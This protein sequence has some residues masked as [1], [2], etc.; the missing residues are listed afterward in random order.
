MPW[1][2]KNPRFAGSTLAA[3]RLHTRSPL[4]EAGPGRFLG[5]ELVEACPLGVGLYQFR[6][7]LILA[8]LPALL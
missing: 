5:P 3:G 7:F 4:V 8:R 6:D 1:S 2:S